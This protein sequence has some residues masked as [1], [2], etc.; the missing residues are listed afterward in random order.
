MLEPTRYLFSDFG[1]LGTEREGGMA[2]VKKAALKPSNIVCALKYAKRD[3]NTD[4]VAESFDRELKALTN[5][6][7]KNIVRLRGV[8][9]DGTQRF[10]ALEWLEE[11]L[12]D[13]LTSIGPYEWAAFYE[14]IGRPLLV[15]LQYAH[16]RSIAHRDLKPLNVMFTR[17][18]VPK[19]TDFGIARAIGEPSLGLTF[20]GA[21]ARTS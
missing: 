5:L 4:A 20:A 17:T 3:A 7:H 21:N 10:L 9:V 18:G 14:Q 15:A 2:V 16:G 6:E 13:K 12:S 1:L 19:I 8:G 11:T